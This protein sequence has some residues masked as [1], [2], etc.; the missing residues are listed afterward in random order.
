MEKSNSCCDGIHPV[1][2]VWLGALTGAVIATM[3]FG[4]KVFEMASNYQ[5]ALFMSSI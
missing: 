5:D 4:Y 3:I 1:I 2:L